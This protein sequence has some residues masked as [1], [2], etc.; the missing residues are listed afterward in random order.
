MAVRPIMARCQVTP[1]ACT[2]VPISG[3]QAGPLTGQATCL[4]SLSWGAARSEPRAL[5]RHA[6]ARRA[7]PVQHA[8]TG[9]VR[10]CTRGAR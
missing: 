10:R 4:A 1:G 3:C 6:P 5:L 8:R 2:G 9:K 7:Y